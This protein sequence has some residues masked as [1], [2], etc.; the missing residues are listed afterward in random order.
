MIDETLFPIGYGV[1][2][3]KELFMPNN[4]NLLIPVVDDFTFLVVN[5]NNN[6]RIV[7]KSIKNGG[8]SRI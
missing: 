6:L 2:H 7:C 5:H 8:K 4:L 1:R 3:K